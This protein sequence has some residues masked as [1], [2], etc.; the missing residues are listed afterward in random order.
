MPAAKIAASLRDLLSGIAVLGTTLVCSKGYHTCQG[1]WNRPTRRGL[2]GA[3]PTKN[4]ALASAVA[5]PSPCSGVSLLGEFDGQFANRSQTYAGTAT[6]RDPAAGPKSCVVHHSK[7]SC[8]MTA[9]GHEPK[10][11]SWPLCQLPPATADMTS[12]RPS[13][14]CARTGCEQ[15][16]R[17]HR[18]SITSSI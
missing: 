10:S 6:V 2:N 9:S 17:N 12:H 3:T 16:Q 14:L 5:E 7:I 4:S 18:H 8:P 1:C 15:L 13:P 11:P